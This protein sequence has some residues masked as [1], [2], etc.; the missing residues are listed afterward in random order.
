M[1]TCTEILVKE[2]PPNTFLSKETA[3]GY[4][5]WCVLKTF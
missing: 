3:Y 2:F 4:G 5:L 1:S